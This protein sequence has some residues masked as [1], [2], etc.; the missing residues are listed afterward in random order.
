MVDRRR[1]PLLLSAAAVVLAIGTFQIARDKMESATPPVVAA[2][3]TL[4]DLS[5][6]AEANRLARDPVTTASITP[7]APAQGSTQ[8]ADLPAQSAG[9]VQAS[10]Q[11]AAL[12]PTPPTKPA[13]AAPAVAPDTGITPAALKQAAQ[14]GNPVAAYEFGARVAE[15]RGMPRDPQLA[16][17]F[18]EKAAEK[19]LAPAQYRTGNLYEKGIGVP[20]DIEAA[21]AWYRRAAENGNTRAMHNL[22]VLL[23]EGAAGKPDYQ[24]AIGWFERAAAQGMR[25]SQFNLAV[26]LARG[27]GTAQNL[28]QS[29][30]WFAVA[31]AGGDEDAAKKRDEVGARLSAPDLT[32]A[33]V[34]VEHWRVTPPNAAANEVALPA[35][36]FAES[37]PTTTA[38]AKKPIREGRV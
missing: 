17:R 15:G 25:D 23:A 27:L 6:L 18:F 31:A 37:A 38:A 12:A 14:A 8:K 34:A 21:K 20:R 29:Y 24:S 36:G 9:P 2:A 13:A 30:T 11:Q 3:P 26:L 22:A 32:R 10:T 19:G 35:N 16:A 4:V 28:S 33:K 7:S 5:E 1:R